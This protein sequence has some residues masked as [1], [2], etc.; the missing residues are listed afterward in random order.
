VTIAGGHDKYE[1]Q[2]SNWVVQMK[3]KD[4][5]SSAIDV[6]EPE[7]PDTAVLR[8][9]KYGNDTSPSEQ[10]SVA[11]PRYFL[12]SALAVCLTFSCPGDTRLWEKTTYPDRNAY[13]MLKSIVVEVLLVYFMTLIGFW[14]VH[15]SD[16]GFLS[17]EILQHLNDYSESESDVP[18]PLCSNDGDDRA[19][20]SVA[21]IEMIPLTENSC[22]SNNLSSLSDIHESLEQGIF[23]DETTRKSSLWRRSKYC[24]VCHVQPLIR[25]HHCKICQR[26]VAT[27]DHHCGFMGV[28]IGERNHARFWFFLLCQAVGFYL[29]CRI[30]G[31]SSLGWTTLLFPQPSALNIHATIPHATDSHGWFDAVRVI[32]AKVYLYPLTLVAWIMLGLHTFFLLCNVTT[33]EF[34]KGPRHIDYLQGTEDMDLPFSQGCVG[35][36]RL[37]CI[38]DTGCHATTWC[39]DRPDE[40]RPY[41]KPILWQ[42]PGK[43]IR[44]SLDW[45]NHPWQNKY[46]SCC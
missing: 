27:F 3:P 32:V 43:I 14:M 39:S 8:S 1:Y 24:D 15:R 30:V 40:N 38:G 2:I 9:Q 7:F 34:T 44:D 42:K 19:S 11:V 21:M 17:Q 12:L 45:W 20:E 41:W 31:S 10:R 25:S 33:F 36:V 28:C 18:Q 26:C 5:D 16:P 37:C 22:E 23:V 35:N 13:V 46:W 6:D 29:C 4:E